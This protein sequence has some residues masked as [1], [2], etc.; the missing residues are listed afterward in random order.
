MILIIRYYDMFQNLTQKKLNDKT[1]LELK[2]ISWKEQ[3]DKKF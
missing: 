2:K 1:K 3:S